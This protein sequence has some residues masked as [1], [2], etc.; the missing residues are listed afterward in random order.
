MGQKFHLGDFPGGAVVKTLPS[1]AGGVGS[2]LG[3]EAKIPRARGQK[4]QNT[5]QKQCCNRFDKDFKKA[6]YQS[7]IY[8]NIH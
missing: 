6:S 7:H 4:K 2:I 3:R 8:L 1:N 5:K